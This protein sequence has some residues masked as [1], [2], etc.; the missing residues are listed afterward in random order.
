MK[1]TQEMVRCALF[2][3]L[4]AM[5]AQLALPVGPVPVNLALLPVLM[6]GMLLPPRTA[7]LSAAVYLAM[8]AVGL[9]V[10]SSMRGGAGHLMGPVG[11]Y[12]AGY[13]LCAGLTARLRALGQG[14][15]RR[16]FAACC[17]GVAACQA[18]GM[19]WF[20]IVTRAGVAQTLQLTLAPFILPDLA[21][22]ALAAW[23]APRMRNA[24]RA[25]YP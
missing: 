6:A 8:G 1:R 23:V 13:V 20:M 21:K 7:A 11:G 5:G 17:A 14:S 19:A 16:D 4:T 18:A 15:F 22:A 9:P 12:V 3:A 10:F 25:R 2:A 24:I